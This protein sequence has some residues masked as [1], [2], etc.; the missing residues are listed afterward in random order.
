VGSPGSCGRGLHARVLTPR[1]V[2][3]AARANASDDVAFRLVRRRRHP[4][5]VISRLSSRPARTHVNASLRPHGS[6]THGLGPP[7]IATPSWPGVLI[8]FLVPVYPALSPRSMREPQ[9]GFTPPSCRAPPGRQ[10]AT[11]A[12]LVPEPLTTP[13]SMPRIVSTLQ[14]RYSC[15]RLPDPHLAHDQRLFPIAHHGL[16]PTQHG[17][18]RLTPPP[19]G[20][21]D[22]PQ[23]SSSC[24]APLQEPPQIQLLSALVAH[25]RSTRDLSSHQGK[26]TRGREILR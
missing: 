6:P 10:N 26:N 13:V 21:A 7:W 12:R 23:P 9:T 2:R 3:R 11:P 24:T 18:G 5:A 14:Q 20:G 16:Q 1:G 8:P 4:E 17:V 15:A 19:L 25:S 22:G